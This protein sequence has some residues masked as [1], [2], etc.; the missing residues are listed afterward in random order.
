MIEEITTGKKVIPEL[1]TLPDAVE[2]TKFM[3]ENGARQ[4]TMLLPLTV[5]VR[6]VCD[7]YNLDVE[8]IC[9]WDEDT[10]EEFWSWGHNSRWHQVFECMMLDRPEDVESTAEL[11]KNAL[12][13]L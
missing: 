4:G 2:T 1:D 10:C 8:V 9:D 13:E 5:W 7:K 11:F 12:Q 6:Q 3:I